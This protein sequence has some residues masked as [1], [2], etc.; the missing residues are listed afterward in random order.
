LISTYCWPL[1]R[2]CSRGDVPTARIRSIGRPL[3]RRLLQRR[4]FRTMEACYAVRVARRG[5]GI[6]AGSDLL[7]TLRQVEGPE[8]GDDDMLRP[9]RPC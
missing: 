9:P 6:V 3:W 4:G 2:V 7:D 1:P 8:C 5:R